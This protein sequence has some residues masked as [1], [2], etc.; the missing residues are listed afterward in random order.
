MGIDLGTTNSALAYVDT[1]QSPRRVETFAIRQL[2]APGVVD[3]RDVLPSFHYQ[4]PAHEA[5]QGALRLPWGDSRP[6]YCVGSYAR[7]EGIA[8]PTRLIASAK[9]WL[10]HAGVDRTAELLPWQGA[11]DVQRLSPVDATARFLAHLRDAWNAQWPQ[12]P[13]ADQDLVVTLPASFDEVARELTVQA[14]R[15]AQLPRITLIEEPQAA[16][17]AWIDRHRDQWQDLVAAGQKILVCDIGGGTTDFT[18]IRVLREKDS[19]RLQ[20]HRVAVG[21]H[22]ILGG[23]NLD[24][25]LA[26]HIE[27]VA[28]PNGKL[29]PQ[30]WDA[31][32]RASRRLKE[33]LLGPDAPDEASVNLP[34]VGSRLIGGGL[35]ASIRREDA[36]RLLVDGFLPACDLDA[37]PDRRRSGFQEMGL[38]YAADP[39]ISRY[40]ASFLRAHRHTGDSL[41]AVQ[42]D[43]S[44]D[45]ARPDVVLLNGQ[46]FA[47]PALRRRLLLRISE[48]FSHADATWE[49][50]VLD[51]PRLDLAVAH[52]AAYYGMVR[53]G[54]GVGI[55]ANLARSYYIGV[56]RD[57]AVANPHAVCLVPGSAR[58]GEEFELHNLEFELAISEPVEFPLYVSSTRLADPPGEVIEVDP[59][60][61]SALPPIRTVLR[62]AR[63]GE[64]P[65]A[66]VHLCARLTEIGSLEMAC[67]EIEGKRSWTLQFD[68]RS[69]T[70]TDVA[71]HESGAEEEGFVDEEILLRSRQRLEAVFAPDGDGKPAALIKDLALALDMDKREW[72]TSL[73]RR[74][75]EVLHELQQGRRRSPAHE[76]RWL[77]LAGYALRPGYGYAVDD[78]RVAETWKMVAG[79]LA[80]PASQ[81]EAMVLWRRIAGGLSRGAQASVA[82]PLV[83]VVRQIH[84]RATGGKASRTSGTLRPTET[85]EIWR[86]LGAFEWLE[87]PLKEELGQI[88]V[89]LLQKRQYQPI[90]G[91]LL[92]ALGRFGQRVPLYGPL[93]TVVPVDRAERW[94]KSVLE[95]PDPDSGVFLAAMQLAR[96]TGDR[97]RDC[98]EAVRGRVVDWMRRTGA[99]TH[100]IELVAAGGSLAAEEQDQV[101]GEAL[102]RGLRL[103]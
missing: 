85:T 40:L 65:T 22:L 61:M 6:D 35:Q 70:Q 91:A 103:S 13:L 102:P 57:D 18:L 86:L 90:R 42:A 25:A 5:E 64:N 44:H 97:H 66:R 95:T 87:V 93:N 19:D 79:K 54:E 4:A 15:K 51:N 77:N 78:W 37:E 99:T 8:K 16:F 24:L 41:E 98:D 73:L 89:D 62:S 17:Y 46:F 59:E 96:K 29:A 71:A 100:L 92:W 88:A 74:M 63:K 7:D 81:A 3:V 68:V 38:P 34:A 31:L 11:V 30:Q 58:A 14:A 27:N 43:A 20:F 82:E 83:G 72:P 75:W 84:R 60:Q 101:Q 47:S 94:L 56:H 1:E 52:G 39:A 67:R 9:S 2:T 48:W 32:I 69:T 33:T 10:C 26:H 23:D 12:H 21:E 55:V 76:S 28:A 80:F 50:L 53:R 45:P 36:E 49:P